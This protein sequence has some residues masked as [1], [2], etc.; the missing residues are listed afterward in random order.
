MMEADCT[1]TDYFPYGHARYVQMPPS[2]YIACSSSVR[3]W[4]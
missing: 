1:G 3:A 4:Q 2:E